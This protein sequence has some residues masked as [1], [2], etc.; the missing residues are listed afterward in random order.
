MIE[1]TNENKDFY[2][3]KIQKEGIADFYEDIGILTM[4]KDGK[5]LQIKRGG[6]NYHLGLY[7]VGN[8]CLFFVFLTP[9]E[10]CKVVGFLSS[11]ILQEHLYVTLL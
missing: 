11:Q 9:S 3:R 2:E 10:M 6:K 8:K 5:T 4:E 1:K 7:D